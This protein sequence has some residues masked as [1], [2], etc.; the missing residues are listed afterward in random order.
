MKKKGF[1]IF[2]ILLA[3]VLGFYF[4][5]TS[6]SVEE[7]ILSEVD[8]DGSTSISVLASNQPS[9]LKSNVD[10]DEFAAIIEEL[11]KMEVKRTNWFSSTRP[12]DGQYVVFLNT[13]ANGIYQVH[14][15]ETANTI[16]FS[17]PNND[18]NESRSYNYTNSDLKEI[19]STI[20]AD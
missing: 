19:I 13:G 11:K 7:D 9:S 20:V 5:L 6:K 14:L 12:T 3:I 15:Y 10:E 8:F 4:F 18:I 2:I 16:S 17:S 1:F